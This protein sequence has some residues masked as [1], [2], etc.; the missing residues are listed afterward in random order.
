MRLINTAGKLYIPGMSRKR[1]GLRLLNVVIFALLFFQVQSSG[2]E[3]REKS[4]GI[5]MPVLSVRRLFH[6]VE[7]GGDI[8]LMKPPHTCRAEAE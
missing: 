3:R 1:S 5:D 2:P 8:A 7:N 6:R 4:D